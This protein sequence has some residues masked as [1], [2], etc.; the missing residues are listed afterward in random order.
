M[1]NEKQKLIKNCDD[2]SIFFSNFC[3]NH[4]FMKANQQKAVY[5]CMRFVYG[6]KRKQF[7]YASCCPNSHV[8]CKCICHM[9]CSSVSMIYATKIIVNPFPRMEKYSNYANAFRSIMTMV[10]QQ[11]FHVI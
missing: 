9:F 4:H 8:Q 5:I 2:S 6:N 10:Y 11:L 7:S 1:K 3:I